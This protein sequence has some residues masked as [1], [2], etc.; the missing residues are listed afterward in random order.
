M[1]LKSGDLQ[2]FAKRV[3][4]FEHT[5][6]E[7]QKLDDERRNLLEILLDEQVKGILLPAV[8]G[9]GFKDQKL[10]LDWYEIVKNDYQITDAAATF[11]EAM[12]ESGLIL[13]ITARS[14][15]T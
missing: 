10:P 6:N 8:K 12:G 7:A 9:S 1:E 3:D 5:F 15:I 2:A 14:A 4:A 11:A 13:A